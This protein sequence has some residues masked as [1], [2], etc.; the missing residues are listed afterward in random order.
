MRTRLLLVA[1]IF[2]LVLSAVRL[3]AQATATLTGIST[4]A[5]GARL[6]HATVVL[7]GKQTGIARSVQT[8]E[9]GEYTIPLLLPGEY[10]V[11]VSQTGFTSK[12]VESIVLQ[13]G[14]VSRLDVALSVGES[15][16]SV[17]VR[18]GQVDL[19]TDSASVGTTITNR[20]VVNMPLNGRQFYT[21]ALLV[22]GV[23]PPVQNSTLGFRGGFNVAGS[24]EVANYFTLDGFNNVD[25]ANGS[26]TVRPSIDDIQEFHV[27]TG[28]YQAEYGHNNGG[29]VTVLTKQ[30]SNA[31]HGTAYEFLRNDIFDARNYFSLRSAPNQLKRNDFGGT[32][33]GPIRSNKTFFFFSYEGLRLVQSVTTLGNV[34]TPQEQAG[35][36]SALASLSTPTGYSPLVVADNQ[37]NTAYMTASQLQAY[38]VG[39]ALLSYYPQQN[40]TGTNNY[41]FTGKRTEHSNQ[42]SMRLDHTFNEKDSLYATLQ[43]FDDP[44]FEPSNALCGSAQIPGFGC[45][46]PYTGQLYGG[47]WNHMFSSTLYN[48]LRI[49]FQRARGARYGED[50][51]IP[52]NET[53]GINAF[54]NPSYPNNGGLPYTLITGFATLGSYVNV[55]QDRRDNLY[56]YADDLLWT[57]GRHSIKFGFDAQRFQNNDLFTL[58]GRGV[59]QFTSA[60]TGGGTGNALADALLGIPAVTLK[61]PTAP[62]SYVRENYFAAYAQDDFKVTPHLALNFG[63]RWEL[64]GPPNDTQNNFANF[65]TTT[66]TPYKLG[67]DG[68]SR[69]PWPNIWHNFGPR[70][71]FSYQPP[72]SR[73]T[74]IRGGF[75][76][77]YNQQPTENGLFN[78]IT[79]TPVRQSQT[80]VSIPSL[81]LSLANPFPTN[82]YTTALTPGG[83][84]KSFQAAQIYEW[85]FGVQHQFGSTLLDV[86]YFGS[87]GRHIPNEINLNQPAEG[88]ASTTLATAG[89]PYPKYG[90]ITWDESEGASNFNSLQVKVQRNVGHGLNMVASYTYGRSLDNTPGIATS[91]NA[92]PSFPQNSHDLNADY[93]RSGFDIKHRFVISPVYELPFGAGKRYATHGI[94]GVLFGGF[95]LS[96]IL[97]VQSG[98]PATPTYASNISNTFNSSLGSGI[99]RPNVHGNPNDGPRNVSEWFDTSVYSKP[100]SGYFGDAGRNS[101]DGPGYT[102][103]DI[104]AAKNFALTSKLQMQAKGEAFN[105]FNHPN[106]YL[107]VTKVDSSTF[108]SIT[109]AYD[110]RQIQLSLRLLF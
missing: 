98:T 30:G 103:L 101:I 66:G 68:T 20:T 85:S 86:A 51:T 38:T 58:Y 11:R 41:S 67:T 75:G 21:L 92:S 88:Y 48:Q 37:I 29:Q 36:F 96:G 56:E 53:Y 77:M 49:G 23:Y 7:T 24:S 25:G 17:D 89:R 12:V 104:A 78:L 5:N 69:L 14:Q 16:T 108:G 87:I 93:G 44:S 33:S 105:L 62:Q 1:C 81:P 35:N 27:Q 76:V 64:F 47:A 100:Q 90:N 9:V 60:N 6:S 54:D 45:S 74:V 80:F 34:P 63:L 42:Y 40:T 55:P 95:Q 52:F 91:D 71:G 4:D 22:P 2:F 8:N 94:P 57:L 73:T 82:A 83:I 107:P 28:V 32:F 10:S 3:D 46:S 19:D 50:D 65:N 43:Y 106:F 18:G 61:T 39:K 79:S 72:L 59:M 26:P 31:W 109:T 99:D 70:V 13:V 15:V 110:P 97:T 102:D 84:A